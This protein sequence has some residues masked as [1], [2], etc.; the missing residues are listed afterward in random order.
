MPHTRREFSHSILAATVAAA[1]PSGIFSACSVSS[2]A[3]HTPDSALL[4][5]PRCV[6]FDTASEI[7]F[8]KGFFWGAT[9]AAYQI[10]GA[11]KEDG[12]GESIW[13]RFAHTPGKIKN[14]DTGDVACDSYHRWREDIALMRAMNLNS[15]RFSI[16][17][18][19]IQPSGAGPANSKGVDYYSRLVD[20]LLE[21]GIRPLVTLYHWDLPQALEDLGGWPNRDTAARFADYVELVSRSL[22]DRVRDWT[23][24]NEP[25]AFVDLGYLE[26]THAP[27]RKSLVDFL[28]ASHAVNLAQGEGFRA[29]KAVHPSARVGTALSMLA[30]E[31]A[32]NSEDDKLAA[33]RAHAI[34]NLWFLDPALK[35]R[36]PDAFT[37]FPETVMGIKSGDLEKMKAPLDFIGINLYYRTIASA[38]TAIERLSHAQQWL[39]PVKMARG[40]QGPKTDMGWEVWPQALYDIV[41]RI[42]RDFNRPVIEITESGC[43]YNDGPD[44]NGVIHDSRRI[45]YHRQY[46][47]AL[48][49][50]MADGADVRGYHAWS[51]MDNFEWAEGFSQRF[52][53]AYVDFKTQKRTIKESGRWYGKVAQ[54]NRVGPV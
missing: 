2:N 20:A 26:G 21:A 44:A 1:L 14:G 35:G 5:S 10:E 6:Q 13:D 46:L 36:Y 3:A 33:E 9:T 37:F 34:T 22:G 23:L 50:A 28:R 30:C 15:Y 42:T 49:Q 18:P 12:K 25:S 4:S 41:T 27:G 43:S 31:P 47:Q 24:F 52:G 19:R 48:A 45:E 29:L 54:E 51:L 16:S 8:P 40:D 7:P 38:S 39:F 32:T 11:W 17:W 53:L